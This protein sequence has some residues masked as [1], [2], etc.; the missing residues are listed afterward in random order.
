MM[1]PFFPFFFYLFSF[2]SLGIELTQTKSCC[3]WRKCSH[4]PIFLS[5]LLF[6]VLNAL[7]IFLSREEWGWVSVKRKKKKREREEC[8][9]RGDHKVEVVC[10]C[11]QCTQN[12]K[13]FFNTNASKTDALVASA[14]TTTTKQQG[15][16]VGR[17]KK[18][19]G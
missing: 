4:A 12:V 6:L 9:G 18:G 3:R 8:E 7:F 2:L 16:S 5:I 10:I 14:T 19:K 11:I 13:S 15:Q 17:G 1:A